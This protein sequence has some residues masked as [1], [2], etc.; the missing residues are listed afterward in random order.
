M[1]RPTLS[2]AG[3][4]LS[5]AAA[6]AVAI[7]AGCSP[8]PPPA[9]PGASTPAPSAPAV[10]AP[11]PAERGEYLVS[12]LGCHDCHSP[13]VY[14]GADPAPDGSRLLSG[15]PA[16][17]ATPP[18]PAGV[19]DPEGWVA[20]TNAHFTAWAGPWGVSYATNLTP[21]A[22]GLGNWTEEQFIQTIRTGRHLGVG[23]PLLPPMPWQD[24][25]HMTDDDLRA[26]FAYLRSLPP[27]AN[28]VPP[29]LPPAA[30]DS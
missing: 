6:V 8:S 7:L 24:F 10:A 25:A 12:I 26:V 1:N 28:A 17:V 22:S 5:L 19:P 29:P 3:A 27:V 20:L 23:R 4:R 13:K 14:T 16:D 18:L 2:P 11:V 21:D 30:P 9:E 15:H